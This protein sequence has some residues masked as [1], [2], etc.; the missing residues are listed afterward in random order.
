MLK[1]ISVSFLLIFSI[2]A[3]C[4]SK[5]ISDKLSS[6][7]PSYIEIAK[8]KYHEDYKVLFNTDSTYLVVFSFV[9]ND[10]EQLYSALRFFVYDD[11]NEKIIFEDNLPNGKVEW[12][13]YNQIQVSTI[14]GIVRGDDNKNNPSVYIY[15]IKQKRKIKSN[16]F[17]INE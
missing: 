12:I 2:G 8:D 6:N 14:P 15:D 5:N 11:K 1:R 4:G 16:Q 7:N 9:K 13:N 17:E 10:A 3:C